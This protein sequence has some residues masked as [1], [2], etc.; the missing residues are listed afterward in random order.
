[1]A[2]FNVT[3]TLK[4]EKRQYYYAVLDRA[5]WNCHGVTLETGNL[6]WG[7]IKELKTN[8]V[9]I[10]AQ[11]NISLPKLSF[12]SFSGDKDKNFVVHDENIV[13]YYPLIG[14]IGFK[15]LEEN[16]VINGIRGKIFAFDK[17]GAPKP[18]S[19]ILKKVY[20]AYEGVTLGESVPTGDE[21]TSNFSFDNLSFK[22]SK[23][24]TPNIAL[25]QEVLEFFVI[26]NQDV[27]NGDYII[28][29]ADQAQGI[30]ES[31]KNVT[32][33]NILKGKK[34]YFSHAY[35]D[36]VLASANITKIFEKYGE[37]DIAE[38]TFIFKV[39]PMGKDA[40]IKSSDLHLS[41]N[42]PA[43][44][45]TSI[46]ADNLAEL[47]TVTDQ[48]LIH[49]G[50]TA[51]FMIKSL[52]KPR[53]T[54]YYY[55][56]LL[57]IN[58]SDGTDSFTFS[59]VSDFRTPS[60]WLKYYSPNNN[61]GNGIC[62]SGENTTSC[63]QD[64]IVTPAT[65]C[66]TTYKP[67]FIFGGGSLTKDAFNSATAKF[68]YTIQATLSSDVSVGE[69][70]IAFYKGVGAAQEDT[71]IDV[72]IH[73]ATVAI[74]PGV[75]KDSQGRFIIK[76]GQSVIFESIAVFQPK[77]KGYYTAE[78]NGISWNCPDMDLETSNIFSTVPVNSLPR[79]FNYLAISDQIARKRVMYYTASMFDN[80]NEVLKR[81][82][83]LIKP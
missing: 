23:V 7:G 49:D 63:A 76:K 20:I 25:G 83:A 69:A 19:D 82:Q 35:T 6:F 33:D 72:N 32:T 50:S 21:S 61:C 52:I 48:Y 8:A 24:G 22:I 17:N 71:P 9:F 55:L 79:V 51:T 64:C 40:Y 31:G 78:L 81:I 42:L 28:W 15:S 73:R 36:F 77:E 11:A 5:D 30:S 56:A 26:A 70:S 29:Q 44:I 37:S 45:T 39:S 53:S 59:L 10:A 4:P 16:I 18:V 57:P 75:N 12:E 54:G 67:R 1:M 41:S 66:S 47:N 38:A 27:K 3:G 60:M 13:G 62:E 65:S 34:I 68:R 2:V 46:S 43:D 14:H 58:W 80:Y 74:T